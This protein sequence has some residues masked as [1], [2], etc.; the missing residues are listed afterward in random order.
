MQRERQIQEI[1]ESEPAK[2][3]SDMDLVKI[4]YVDTP[5]QLWK[6]AAHNVSQHLKKL[7]KDQMIQ[8]E[9]QET[10]DGGQLT[11]WK[12]FTR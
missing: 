6:A 3:F 2:W 5:E 9:E 10:T 11:K 1:L 4:I 8:S 7:Q 12:Y